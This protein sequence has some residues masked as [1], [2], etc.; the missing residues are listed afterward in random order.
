M[1]LPYVFLWHFHLFYLNRAF[2]GSNIEKKVIMSQ[3]AEYYITEVVSNST[4]TWPIPVFETLS[5]NKM[6]SVWR[7]NKAYK[8]KQF[9]LFYIKNQQ[10]STFKSLEVSRQMVL[11]LYQIGPDLTLQRWVTMNSSYSFSTSFTGN[12]NNSFHFGTN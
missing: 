10:V 3:R 12:E 7:Q 8:K 5:H 9:K 1:G 6:N 11:S 2:N 4:E